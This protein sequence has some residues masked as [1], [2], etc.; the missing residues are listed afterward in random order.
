MLSPYDLN[1]CMYQGGYSMSNYSKKVIKILKNPCLF[2]FIA[3]LILMLFP[4]SE[5]V[6]STSTSKWN[7]I[8]GIITHSEL[9]KEYKKTYH[10]DNAIRYKYFIE[11]KYEIDSITYESTYISF[12]KVEPKKITAMYPKGSN[13]IVFYNPQKLS[14]SV[15]QHGTKKLILDKLF[16]MSLFLIVYSVICYLLLFHKKSRL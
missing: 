5:Y 7:T 10:N 13:I 6:K 11:Y 8:E 3:G 15:L 2:M 12:R 1:K 9:I 14:E 4:L 16:A